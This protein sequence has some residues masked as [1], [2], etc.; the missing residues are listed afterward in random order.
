MKYL[1]VQL[2][3]LNVVFDFVEEGGGVERLG[4]FGARLVGGSGVVPGA[5]F[6]VGVRAMIRRMAASPH[7]YAATRRTH[8]VA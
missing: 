6:L 1:A 8:A 2:K 7:R 3:R 5:G 4:R